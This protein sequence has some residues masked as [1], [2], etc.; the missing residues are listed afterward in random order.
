MNAQKQ[1]TPFTRWLTRK[2]REWEEGQG[3]KSSVS[4]WA[5][6]LGVKQP[7]LNRWLRGDTVPEAS[8]VMILS[9]RLGAEVYEVLGMEA[10]VQIPVSDLPSGFRWRLEAATVEARNALIS[11]GLEVDSASAWSLVSEVF[12]R[13]GFDVTVIEAK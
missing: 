4:E 13:H 1:I 11:S 3:G 12:G 2:Y 10:P 9:G 7:T 5:R 8:N 6:Y